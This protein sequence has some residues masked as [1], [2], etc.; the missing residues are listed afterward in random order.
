MNWPRVI[1]RLWSIEVD[2]DLERFGNPRPG[3][4]GSLVLWN[5]PPGQFRLQGLALFR[6]TCMAEGS[7]RH[8]DGTHTLPLGSNAQSPEARDPLGSG[9]R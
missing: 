6:S 7:G 9:N 5:S 3:I 1:P 8:S 4:P 2:L